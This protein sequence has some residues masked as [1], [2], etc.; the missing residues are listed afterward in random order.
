VL[1]SALLQQLDRPDR[2]EVERTF[3]EIHQELRRDA[4]AQAAQA[5]IDLLQK[6]P[7]R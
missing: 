1:G 5:V 4:S 7:T 6:E 3:T 2:D